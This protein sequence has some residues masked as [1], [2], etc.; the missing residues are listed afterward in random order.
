MD[1][2]PKNWGDNITLCAALTLRGLMAPLFLP[3]AMRGVGSGLSSR[4]EAAGARLVSLPP[5]SP[6]FNPIELCWSKVKTLLR[7]AKART[8]KA[9]LRAVTVALRSVTAQDALG[10][11]QHNGYRGLQ[12]RVTI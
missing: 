12:N 9:L 5:Y 7:R 11:F 1:A 10:W 8:V 2:T 4:V 3:G 6:N